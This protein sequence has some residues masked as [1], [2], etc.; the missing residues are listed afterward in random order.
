[1]RRSDPYAHAT[2]LGEQIARDSK[3]DCLAVDPMAIAINRGILVQQKPATSAG[4][5]GM[6][7]RVGNEYAIAYAT[8][9]ENEGFQRFSVGH[10]LGHYFLPGHMDAVFRDGD[11][12]ES[13]AG[14]GSDDKYELE[15]DHF[16]AGLLMPRYLFDP[17]IARAG[18]GI[19]AIE[20]LSSRCKTSLLST[21]IR[22]VECSESPMAIAVSTG[23]RI[24]YCLMSD[25]LRDFEDI[26][27]PRKREPL[28]RESATRAFNADP[29]KVRGAE[30]VESTV[31]F[32]TWFGGMRK[33]VEIDEDVIGLGSYG[34]TL[35][36][37]YGIPNLDE[38]DNESLIESYQP[39]FRK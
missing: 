37:L 26:E 11:V 39:R 6:L 21:A 12:H 29:S 5:S 33:E 35:T 25:A 34:K 19:R 24:D 1:M 17:A 8:H 14:F 22:Y 20:H 3:I 18:S 15:A 7:L 36:M 9:I 13:H 16:A 10:E 27:W 32:Q 23:D 31:S 28:P 30:R 38:D 4:V 2:L